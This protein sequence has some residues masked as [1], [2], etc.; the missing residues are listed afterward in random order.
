MYH[1]I[2]GQSD[3]ASL[4]I[5]DSLAEWEKWGMKFH[6]DKCETITITQKQT[7]QASYTLRGHL[8]KNV[9]HAKYLGINIAT[10]L[11][12]KSHNNKCQY[13]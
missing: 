12:W 9:S 13:G 6:P 8:L 3:M 1:E 11:D 10:N 5:I 7:L 4:Q 2:E